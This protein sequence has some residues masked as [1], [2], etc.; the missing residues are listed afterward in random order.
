LEQV[1]EICHFSAGMRLPPSFTKAQVAKVAETVIDVLGMS[2]IRESKIG[3]DTTRGISGGQRKRVN[4]AMGE[5]IV[6]KTRRLEKS[7]PFPAVSDTQ[8]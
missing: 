6:S 5:S 4:I 8:S 7:D 1:E 3:D 2:H